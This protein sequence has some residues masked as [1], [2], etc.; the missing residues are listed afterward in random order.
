MITLFDKELKD[1]ST[2]SS[3][4]NQLKWEKEN[5]WY[6]ADYLG[7]EGLA[8]YVVSKLLEKS[9]LKENEYVNYSL[10]EISYKAAVFTGCCSDDFT[11]DYSVITLER[12]FKSSYGEG[13]NKGIYSIVNHTERLKYLVAQVERLTGITDFGQYMCKLFTIDAF[14]LN[15]DRHTHNISVL[16]RGDSDFKLCPIYDNGAALLADTMLDYPIGCDLGEAISQ[17]RTKTICDSP[18]E[19]LEIAESLY[20]QGVRFYWDEKDV[21]ACLNEAVIYSEEIRN[22]VK[23]ILFMQKRKY[24]YLFV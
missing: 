14:F 7:Y 11:G 12:L 24:S 13:L 15:E 9:S 22:R 20:G 19:Q 2:R 21:E 8:E 5:V 17:V 6:K 10:E 1:T 3:K 18:E 23:E 4:G 16:M